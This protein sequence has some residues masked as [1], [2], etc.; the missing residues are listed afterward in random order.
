[1]ITLIHPE[2]F[3]VE[4]R[5]TGGVTVECHDADSTVALLFIGDRRKLAALRDAAQ[6]ALDQFDARQAPIELDPDP[7]WTILVALYTREDQRRVGVQLYGWDEQDPETFEAS[8]R[9]LWD[10][11]AREPLPPHGEMS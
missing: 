9:I 4:V 6:E 7:I 11:L 2:E 3:E 1:M 10:A 8:L 5:P